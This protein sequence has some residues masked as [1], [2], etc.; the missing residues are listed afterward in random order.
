M[1]YLRNL[2][3]NMLEDRFTL[4]ALAVAIVMVLANVLV[5]WKF[6]LPAWQD[7]RE[8]TSQLASAE[9][10][11]EKALKAQKTNPDELRKQM[12]AAQAKLDD[13]ASVFLSDS[14]ATEALNKLYQYASESQ[15]EITSLETQP[16]PEGKEGEEEE[17]SVHEVE[18]L[19]LQAGGTLPS[20]V[21][22]VS[23]IEE[24]AFEG[25]VITNVNITEGEKQQ[26]TLSMDIALYTSPYS[27]G[28]VAQPTPGVTVTPTNLAELDEALATAWASGEWEQAI[29]LIEQILVIEPD[30][31]D[32]TEKLYAAHVNYGRQLLGEGDPDE[33]T[34]QFNSALEIKADGP[35]AQ[36][37]LQQAL[38]WEPTPTTAP[39]PSSTP[40]PAL[41]EEEQLAQSLH[42][43]W[44]E[45]DWEEVIS[46]IEQI[47]AINS[48]Y[49]DM[50]E[51]LY[52]AHV[53]YGRQL[54]AEGKLEEA[55]SEFTRALDV[56]PDGGEAMT[57]L[58]AL[59]AGE[60]P[61]PPTTPTAPTTPQP[62][63]V[64]YVVRQGDTLYSIARWYGTTVQAIMAANGLTSYTI[65]P[66]Q[67]LRIP[68]E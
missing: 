13:V 65:H 50:A 42:E 31:A 44:A 15:V 5:A 2:V 51:K 55:K 45:E 19:R 16:A 30:Y 11:L 22:F 61:T 28:A 41:T 58:R 57:E 14:Q 20:L 35:E 8:L 38:A 12:E 67:Q 10:A 48:D 18:R 3:E 1:D 7:R 39:T 60:T 59:A 23:H 21:D 4:L 34:E 53:N 32:M 49:D 68:T 64:T 47:L 40:A 54:A 33:A 29:G 27:T 24:A 9:K 37:G 46:L 26:H 6:I 25:F 62:Q 66:G 52:A 63:Y 43:P 36:A 56:K 17:K